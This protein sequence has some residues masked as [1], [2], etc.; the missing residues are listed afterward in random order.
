MGMKTILLAR[1]MSRLLVVCLF[2]MSVS[3]MTTYDRSG[4]PVKSVDPGAATVGVLAAA[5]IGYALANGDEE[6]HYDD[7]CGHDRGYHDRRS[8]HGRGN[9]CR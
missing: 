4:R 5:L 8:H 1:T 3:C 2:A 9:H 6:D 7:S